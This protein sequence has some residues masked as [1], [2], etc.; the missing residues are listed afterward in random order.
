MKLLS[1]IKR[2]LAGQQRPENWREARDLLESDEYIIWLKKRAGEIEGQIMERMGQH[3]DFSF[4]QKE[5]MEILAEM[6]RLKSE[7]DANKK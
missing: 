6:A 4:F 7:A 1:K 3:R 2:I 5:K